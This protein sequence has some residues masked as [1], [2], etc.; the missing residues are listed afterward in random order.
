MDYEAAKRIIDL[1]VEMDDVDGINQYIMVLMLRTG[2]EVKTKGGR[3]QTTYPIGINLQW[4]I[5]YLKGDPSPYQS[6]RFTGRRS[7]NLNNLIALAKED[8]YAWKALHQLI[9]KFNEQ[10][11]PLPEQLYTFLRHNK[12]KPKKRFRFAKNLYRDRFISECFCFL[13]KCNFFPFTKSSSDS[14]PNSAC[15]IIAKSLTENGI[16]IDYE[17]VKSI[18]YNYKDF[19]EPIEDSNCQHFV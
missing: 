19:Y 15:H 5:A 13:K 3:T 17:G 11:D 16:S 18:Q 12:T 7:D 4:L 2:V 6:L 10:N 9:D 8:F 1:K 14:E